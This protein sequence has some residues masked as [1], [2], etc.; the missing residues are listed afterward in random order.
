MGADREHLED[1][2]SY[3]LIHHITSSK[4]FMVNLNQISNN[5]KQ[6]ECHIFMINTNRHL[7]KNKINGDGK[8][9]TWVF[10]VEKQGFTKGL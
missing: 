9:Q 7:F 4:N 1:N 6:E 2:K 3:Y 5:H 10:T 8:I